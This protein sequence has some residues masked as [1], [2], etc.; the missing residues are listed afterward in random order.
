M[1]QT[2]QSFPK[3]EWWATCRLTPYGTGLLIGHLHHSITLPEESTT[4][5]TP[6]ISAGES[7]C[8]RAPEFCQGMGGHSICRLGLRCS[9]DQANFSAEILANF[10]AKALAFSPQRR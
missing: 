1:T 5:L 6:D 10:T 9:N 2:I 3:P 7:A 4:S 8:I